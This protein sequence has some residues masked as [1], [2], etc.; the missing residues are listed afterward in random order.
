[1]LRQVLV[2]LN[3]MMFL[4]YSNLDD[5]KRDGNVERNVTKNGVGMGKAGGN[6]CASIACKKDVVEGTN[7]CHGCLFRKDEHSVVNSELVSRSSISPSITAHIP[8]AFPSRGL[9]GGYSIYLSSN[10]Y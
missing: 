4:T 6:T 2:V 8:A 10:V 7:Y 9:S 1:M 3:S 5:Q